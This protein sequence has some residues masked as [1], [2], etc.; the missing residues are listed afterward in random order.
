[1]A[2]YIGSRGV[3]LFRNVESNQANA[4]VLADGSYFFPVGSVRRSPNWA[5]V[6]IRRTDGNSWY[7]GFV[8]SVT[9]RF[10]GGFQFQ[11][12]YTLGRSHD[13]GSL[14][15]GSQ[16]FS[17]GFPPRYADDRHDN[18][19]LS[20]FDVKHNLT[21]NYS[22]TLPFGQSLSGV[23]RA[24]AAGW[25]V[26]GIVTVRSGVPFTPVLSFDRARALPRSG[27]DG[28]RPHWAPGFNADNVI[29]GDPDRYFDPE[30]FLLPDAGTFGNVPRN[31]LRGPGYGVWN[32]AVFKNF[33]LGGRRRLQLR[34]EGFNLL[35]RANFALP[36]RVVFSAAGPVENAG[37]ITDIV[38]TA[39]QI[40]LGV[41]L[42][43]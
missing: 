16:D 31:A 2:G 40:Q 26:S 41:K 30:A 15:A 36:A 21:F 20:D 43:F 18:H 29:L 35:N 42:D 37:E 22:W 5:A 3:S 25:Q 24:L 8:T 6:R 13:E 17:N 10:S 34:V 27:G 38:G 1:M 39:R 28:Q 33:E 4:E 32:A 11:G 7:N 23:G 12:S 14:S 9:K 19:G